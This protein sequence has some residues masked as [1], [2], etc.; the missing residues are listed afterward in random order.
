MKI[1]LFIISILGLLLT[2]KETS[3]D[4][5]SP[6]IIDNLAY[7]LGIWE[8]YHLFMQFLPLIIVFLVIFLVIYI[9][10]KI[11]K[12]NKIFKGK[13]DLKNEIPK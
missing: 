9:I 12:K 2:A 1:Q 5:I 8:G 7:E 3:A 4:V 11:K 6:G 13:D 10:K